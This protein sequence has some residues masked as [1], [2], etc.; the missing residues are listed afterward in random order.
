MNSNY[1]NKDAVML[2]SLIL[3]ALRDCA[4]RGRVS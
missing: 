2:L 1:V 4:E 3:L